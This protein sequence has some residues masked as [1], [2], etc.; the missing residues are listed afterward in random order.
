MYFCFIL[1]F[2]VF[3]CLYGENNFEKK[4]N[5]SFQMYLNFTIKIYCKF[6]PQLIDAKAHS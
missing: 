3:T 6:D 4:I 1:S 2:S 5:E